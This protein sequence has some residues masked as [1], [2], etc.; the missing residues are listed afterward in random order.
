[1]I[2]DDL[3]E[4]LRSAVTAEPPLGFSTEELIDKARHT[5]RRRRT[6]LGSLATVAAVAIGTV[7]AVTVAGQ[8]AQPP[9]QLPTMKAASTEVEKVGES[10]AKL[11]PRYLPGATRTAV[12][13][14]DNGAAVTYQAEGK[15]GVVVYQLGEC[16][17]NPRGP[18]CQ[19]ER[20][21]QD[22]NND[23]DPRLD[24]DSGIDAFPFF[25]SRHSGS[26]T[27]PLR[28]LIVEDG[29]MLSA[30]APTACQSLL[31]LCDE[32][33]DFIPMS[34][35]QTERVIIDDDL[36]QPARDDVR[37]EQL[38]RELTELKKKQQL[39]QDRQKALEREQEITQKKIELEL[40]KKKEQEERAK[41]EQERSEGK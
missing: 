2:E 29:A 19:A 4:G 41:Q 6:V 38:E 22:P 28:L 36:Y 37:K 21:Q 20:I 33:V 34:N 26:L 16:K 5:A 1:M 27:V 14:V 30:L 17:T 10:I 25:A 12:V 39:E 23:D 13:P 40:L 35:D 31:E 11:I 18:V 24:A 15:P 9:A 7:G 32:D 8:S 3:R